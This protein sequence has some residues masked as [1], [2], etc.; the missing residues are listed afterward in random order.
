M[1]KSLCVSP[2]QATCQ[3]SRWRCKFSAAGGNRVCPSPPSSRSWWCAGSWLTTSASTTKNTTA[4]RV[5]SLLVTL[6][7]VH[8]WK[9]SALRL[10][11]ICMIS[12][13]V[14]DFSGAYEWAQ[15]TLKDHAKDK[16]PYIYTREQL[17]KA[18][19]HDKLWNGA[20]VQSVVWLVPK[21][22]TFPH[23]WS[24]IVICSVK[25]SEATAGHSDRTISKAPKN[26]IMHI[27]NI[28]DLFTV[29][30][31]EVDFNKFE[32]SW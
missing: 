7:L 5:S 6:H 21:T 31:P 1:L 9:I 26:I 22:G 2:S 3:R 27:R 8:A 20:Q 24:E 10:R 13:S 32:Q 15:K 19:T 11:M 16:R 23:P 18:K 30:S 29:L 25:T 14:C 28:K 17:E 12:A 4:W